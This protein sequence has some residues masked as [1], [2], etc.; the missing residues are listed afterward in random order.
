[1]GETSLRKQH[2]ECQNIIACEETECLGCDMQKA[3]VDTNH[4]VYNLG[5]RLGIGRV[6]LAS[7]TYKTHTGNWGADF[8]VLVLSPLEAFQASSLRRSIMVKKAFLLRIGC[9]LGELASEEFLM[10]SR[11]FNFCRVNG[12]VRKNRISSMY[13]V[14]KWES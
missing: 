8:L 6:F 13:T 5:S 11:A 3:S 4:A 1:M 9:Y 14:M 2:Q 12:K 7:V 10:Y